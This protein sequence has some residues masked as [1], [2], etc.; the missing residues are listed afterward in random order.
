M[1]I[2]FDKNGLVKWTHCYGPADY[3]TNV[4][5]T[6][7]GGYIFLGASRYAT[8]D[9][10]FHWGDQFHGNGWLVKVD[11]IGNIQWSKILGGTGGELPRRVKEI[12]PGKYL[13]SITTGSRD[14]M[15]L[16]IRHY[17][18]NDAWICSFD[19]VGDILTSACVPWYGQNVS[20][21]DFVTL[22]NGD[23]VGVGSV[24]GDS[25]G[26][27]VCNTMSPS[28]G[29]QNFFITKLNNGLG[30]DWCHVEVE[31]GPGSVGILQ[32]IVSIG[33]SI[34]LICGSEEPAYD[35]LV[36]NVSDSTL[37]SLGW[38]LAVN[39]NGTVLWR[40]TLCGS[41]GS[42]MN[43]CIIDKNTNSI[44]VSGVGNSTNGDLTGVPNYGESDVWLI[45]LDY[46]P[47][48][49]SDMGVI[50]NINIY[51]NPVSDV[52][53]IKVENYIEDEPIF[54]SIINTFGQSMLSTN[55]AGENTDVNI[56][57]LTSGLYIAEIHSNTK[58]VYCKKIIKE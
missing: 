14:S 24:A 13:T 48:G 8:G 21:N 34:F 30:I 41:L 16:N 17:S 56:Q 27:N 11:S 50:N 39:A 6:S 33:D 40:K 29:V 20:V 37:I 46:W 49:L 19:S 2:K 57:N 18:T 7:D 35:S 42:A 51:P 9:V 32:S 36:C 10:P 28:N 31:G 54:L 26:Q 22:A 47:N 45:K 38:L 52:I 53:K 3:I 55:I 25:S 4:E 58:G 23:I 1:L 5:P 12:S 44:Y 15:L 43:N